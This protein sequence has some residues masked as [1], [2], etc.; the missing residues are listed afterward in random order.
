[1]KLDNERF[2]V[3]I[4]ELIK[5]KSITSKVPIKAE[6]WEELI[7][8]TLAFMFGDNKINWNPQ[9]HE[10]SIDIK[11]KINDD[12]LKISAKAGEI[13]KNRIAI[14]SYRLTTYGNLGDKLKF[15]K[16]Q[17]NNFDFYLIC[18]RKLIKETITYY[19][20]KAS[21]DKLAPQWLTS[22]NNWIETKNGY[23][24]KK[25]FGFDAR[26]VFK[27]SHQLWYYIPIDYFSF[28]DRIVKI[29]IPLKY[30]GKGLISYLRNKFK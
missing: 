25:G 8:A 4:K 11:V 27:M 6:S 23:E 30:L 10:K 1:M 17:H 22:E 29:A 15:I 3:I 28:Q 19:V 26:I 14:S 9:S 16:R 18:A 2:S 21:S 24:L 12:I 20:I 5:I 13:K 7:W